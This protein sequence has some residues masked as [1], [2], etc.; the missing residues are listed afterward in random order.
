[1]S[2]NQLPVMEQLKQLSQTLLN[3]SDHAA[4][5]KLGQQLAQQCAQMDACLLQSLIELHAAHT[6]LQAILTLL[7]HRDEPLLFSSDEAAA[8]LEP[9]QQHLHH[10]VNGLNLL[11]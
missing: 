4:L 1:M 8:L 10:G 5:P 9:V 3:A 2:Q 11:V 6:G 7:Q